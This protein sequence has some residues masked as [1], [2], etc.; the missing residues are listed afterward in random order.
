VPSCCA[1]R[2]PGF[3]QKDAAWGATSN[4][5]GEMRRNM[6]AMVKGCTALR[7]YLDVKRVLLEDR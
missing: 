5:T 6:Y 2:Q 3:G 4:E 1:F 7:N